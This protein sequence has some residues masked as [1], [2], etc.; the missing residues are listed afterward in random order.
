[1][2]YTR[3]HAR[4]HACMHTCT[5]T[6]TCM[7][8]GSPATLSCW[9]RRLARAGAAPAPHTHRPRPPQSQT[10]GSQWLPGEASAPPGG[11]AGAS[12]KE[13]GHTGE[14]ACIHQS[15]HTHP[16][17]ESLPGAVS[18]RCCVGCVARLSLPVTRACHDAHAGQP[19]R[20]VR[21]AAAAAAA[22]AGGREGPTHLLPQERPPRVDVRAPRQQQLC[23][24]AAPIPAGRG[25]GRKAPTDPRAL[26]DAAT[27]AQHQQHTRVDARTRAHR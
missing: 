11:G 22:A 4:M 19:D 14:R 26:N 7:H 24:G 23:G 20:R 18:A 15:P 16:A 13:V 1:M 25:Q 12:T 10:R 21:R 9:G 17:D 8:A 2:H 27:P 5:H 3:M 6:H